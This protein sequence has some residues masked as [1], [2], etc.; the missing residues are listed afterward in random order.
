M[1][2][3]KKFKLEKPFPKDIEII[4]I[5]V[6]NSNEKMY[7]DLGEQIIIH[8]N[9]NKNAIIKHVNHFEENLVYEYLDVWEA[10]IPEAYVEFRSWDGIVYFGGQINGKD[11]S[12]SIHGGSIDEKIN[13][14]KE[15]ENALLQNF[16]EKKMYSFIDEIL[17][18]F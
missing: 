18:L 12:L 8:Y 1:I 13:V 15:L 17:R 5:I 3:L 10:G 7:R 2:K 16:S 4:E 11:W 6:A 9:V 14:S